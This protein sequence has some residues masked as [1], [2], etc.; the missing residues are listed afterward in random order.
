MTMRALFLADGPSDLPLATHLEALCAENG[1]EVQVTPIDPRHLSAGGRT[2]EG[3]LRIVLAQDVDPDL[4]FIH[5]DAEA[6]GP[7]QRV[8]EVHAGATAAGVPLKK[9]VP[10]V[11]VRMTEAWL[12]L[13]EAEIRRV[14]GRPASS[15]VLGLPPIGTVETIPDPK[16]LLQE[17]LMKAGAPS[18]R[19]RRRQFERDF[20][21]H[22]A[23]L[24]QRLDLGGPINQLSAWQRLKGNIALALEVDPGPGAGT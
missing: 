10:V 21:Q 24:L 19:R 20:G 22:R 13:D 18:G 5:R 6:Q 16:A 9:V 4:V 3:R 23:L 7:E 2:V 17:A 8:A 15:N 12:V 11:P 14:A 1:R